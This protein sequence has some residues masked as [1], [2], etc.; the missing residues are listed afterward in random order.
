MIDFSD[1]WQWLKMEV[2][3]KSWFLPLI[4]VLG[5][6]F[7]FWR[8]RA[9]KRYERRNIELLNAPNF[10]FFDFCCKC[11]G[12]DQLPLGS[13]CNDS[14]LSP[15]TCNQCDDIH[16]FNVQYIGKVAIRNFSVALISEKDTSSLPIIIER[17]L[18]KY[19]HIA[20][21][22][23]VQYKLP[24]EEIQENVFNKKICFSVLIEYQSEYSNIKYRHVY[25][26]CASSTD[27]NDCNEWPLNLTFFNSKEETVSRDN[28]YNFPRKLGAHIRY[29]L[30]LRY[31]I[32]KNWIN[33]F[34][35]KK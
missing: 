3:S 28:W 11:R 29:T 17:R 4:T 24:K 13:L 21:D 7:A 14:N 8:W 25:H 33:D 23:V 10:K 32:K 31:S 5:G 22:T 18:L 12:G 30:N 20:P 2:L 9:D 6:I 34:W 27:S 16:W 26:L 35:R 15:R 19:S 1:T